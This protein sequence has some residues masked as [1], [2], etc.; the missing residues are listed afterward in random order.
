MSD[1]I[2]DYFQVRENCFSDLGEARRKFCSTRT[3]EAEYDALEKGLGI[4]YLH[5]PEELQ[6]IVLATMDEAAFRRLHFVSIWA[7][8]ELDNA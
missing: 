6:I 5:C 7:N 3:T 1:Q 4:M 8:Q 2:H